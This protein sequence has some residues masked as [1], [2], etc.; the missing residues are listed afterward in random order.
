MSIKT[1]DEKY[2]NEISYILD[3]LMTSQHMTAK[4]VADQVGI[5]RS[6]LYKIIKHER[7]P[8]YHTVRAL[9][10]LCFGNSEINPA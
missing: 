4:E 2:T 7:A 5:S 8:R 10:D 3:E 9:Q 6:G 1:N